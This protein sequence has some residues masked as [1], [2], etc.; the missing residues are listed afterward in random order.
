MTDTSATPHPV[1]PLPVPEGT[2]GRLTYGLLFQIAD[3][4][5]RNG[6]PRPAGTDWA[7]LMLALDRFLYQPKETS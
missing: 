6:F 7:D 5:T 2:D 3:V 4:L 1:Y